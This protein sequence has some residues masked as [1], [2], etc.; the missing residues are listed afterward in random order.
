MRKA[1]IGFALTALLHA[2]CLP[3]W[4]QE[5]AKI[6]RIGFLI[7]SSPSANAARIEAFRQGLRELGYAEREK[8]CY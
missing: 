1:V 8:H 5:P 3:V 7:G 6:P 2:L 4:A